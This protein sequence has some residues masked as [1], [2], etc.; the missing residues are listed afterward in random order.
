MITVEYSKL[1]CQEALNKA[2][3][4]VARIR[5]TLELI[6][7]PIRPDG[8]YNRD[9][10]AC[11][12]LAKEAL[13]PAPEEPFKKDTSIETC[14]SQKDAEWRELGPDEERVN[15]Q[16]TFDKPAYSD[17]CRICGEEYGFHLSLIHI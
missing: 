16:F 11:E 15:G 5:S 6:A 17:K 7:A 14:P 3:N 12:L 8:T 2:T 9:R 10:R 1:L 13:E 4:E